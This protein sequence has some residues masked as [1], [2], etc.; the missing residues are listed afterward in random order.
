MAKEIQSNLP[1]EIYPRSGS[2]KNEAY[3]TRQANLIP[4]VVYGPKIGREKGQSNSTG[5]PVCLDPRNFILVY[6][7][8]G[9]TTLVDLA[10]KE[11]APAEL[12]GSKVLIKDLQTHTLKRDVVHVDI[13]QLDLTQALRV[14]V[15]LKFVGKAKGL[16]D[17]G[18]LSIVSRQ[19]EIK[20]LPAD[21]PH[22]IEV[23]VSELGVNESIHIHQ[24]AEKLKGSKYEFI[25]DADYTLCAI[26][27]PEEEKVAAP[28]A[29]DAAAA[30]AAAPAAGAAAPAAGAAAPAADA[31]KDAK[32]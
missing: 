26:V 29:A 8:K 19:A 13:L 28:V 23:D 2:G 6:Q 3:R 12:Q 24:L 17:G 22:E 20:C 7:S 14:S 16:S 15:P 21:I 25:F 1:L 32:K 11:G 10:L 5:I 4:A 18:I 27:P 31:K 9:R 30:G